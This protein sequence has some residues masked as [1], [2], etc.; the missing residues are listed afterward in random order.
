MTKVTLEFDEDE[1][2]ELAAA[3]KLAER[4][5]EDFVIE[6]MLSLADQINIHENLTTVTLARHRQAKNAKFFEQFESAGEEDRQV[7][8]WAARQSE[9]KSEA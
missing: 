2:E 8:E 3:A 4:S 7:A 1:Y 5:V 6:E 9:K